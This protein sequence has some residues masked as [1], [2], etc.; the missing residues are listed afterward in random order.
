VQGL[1]KQSVSAAAAH[2]LVL[3]SNKKFRS[4][5][6]LLPQPPSQCQNLEQSDLSGKFLVAVVGQWPPGKSVIQSCGV[7]VGVVCVIGVVGVVGVVVVEEQ[8][9]SFSQG[10]SPHSTSSGWLQ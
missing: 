6:W 10:L 7:V 9:S 4:H 2:S 3:T 5:C 1:L 8:C